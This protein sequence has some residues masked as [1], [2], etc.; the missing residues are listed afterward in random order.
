MKRFKPANIPTIQV[1]V[2]LIVYLW[3]GSDSPRGFE[4]TLEKRKRLNFGIL[5]E[6]WLKSRS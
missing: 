2:L 1:V 4:N 5:R 3:Y 6:I